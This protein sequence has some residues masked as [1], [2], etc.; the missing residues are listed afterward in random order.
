MER[1][2]RELRYGDHPS[3]RV[4]VLG[5]E[6]GGDGPAPV[7][8]LL[9]GG[10]WR[11]R[12]GMELMEP[13]AEDL[14]RAGWQVW[15]VEYRRTGADGG[16]WPQTLDDVRAAL[17]LL[18]EELSEHPEGAAPGKVVAVGHSAGGHLALLAAPGSP[19]RGV[20]GLAPVTDMVDTAERGLGEGAVDAFLGEEA[21][22]SA[23]HESS[24]LR[25]VPVGVP[26]LIVHGDQDQRVPIEQSRTYVQEARLAGDEV[27]FEEVS[28]A[29]HFVMID[30]SHRA[31]A[32]ARA[33]MESSSGS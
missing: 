17:V 31:W 26:Q 20:V 8:V 9:H 22:H 25:Q 18:S 7:A 10:F 11:D 3:Q 30:P 21:P 14:V 5:P 19:L 24:P 29:D 28:G 12:H 16:G 32:A 1:D 33:W 2:E 15:N 4:R 6:S 23:F 13:I 27:D